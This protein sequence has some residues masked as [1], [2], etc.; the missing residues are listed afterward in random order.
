MIKITEEARQK[1]ISVLD[2]NA[3]PILRFGLQGG[4]CSGF[5]YN[6]CVEQVAEEGDIIHPLDDTHQLVVDS[7]SMMYLEHAELDY[8][9]D[10]TSECFTVHNPDAK[11]KCGCGQS[12]SVD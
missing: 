12:F 10:L 9:K 6:F 1:I 11:T 3:A 2:E 5:V 8:K 4:G 7:M